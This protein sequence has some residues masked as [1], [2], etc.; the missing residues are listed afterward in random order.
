[1]KGLSITFVLAIL[2]L[3]SVSLALKA[4]Y[5]N[6]HVYQLQPKTAEQLELV[7]QLDGSRDSYIFLDA[8]HYVNSKIHV[9][10]AP[11]RVPDFVK[12]LENY[13]I[14]YELM[15]TN[16]QAHLEDDIVANPNRRS[17]DYSWTEYHEL[18]DT[19]NWL[20][21]LEQKY[22]GVVS[23]FKAG[24]TYEGRDILGVKITYG[25]GKK[26]I[27]LEGGMHAREW[28]GPATTT[29]ILNQL[30]SST[31]K[32]VRMIAESFDWYIVPHANPDG[33]VYTHT[34][35]RL[36]RKTRT[37]Y[38]NGCFGA[39]PNRNWDFHWNEIGASDNPCS[40]TYAGPSAFS[41]IETKTLAEYIATELKGKIFLFVSFHSYSQLLLFPYGHTNEL[42]PNYNDLKRVFDVA[43]DAAAERYGTKYTG[44]NIYDAIYPAAGASLDWAY[45]TQ[46]VKYAYCYE[47]RPSSLNF[48]TGF[49]L[50][51]SQIIPTG[52][53]TMDSLMA[54]IKEA[55]I[56]H[57]L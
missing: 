17:D 30:L 36:W 40:D 57:F 31:D 32:E 42:P 43:I 9:V 15:E 35:D 13:S 52:E 37:P 38:E 55:G 39:D 2:G 47:L 50:P 41:E 8:V 1:M 51:A 34:T 26:G 14:A 4:R 49:K 46:G 18:E 54:M 44:G 27:F 19:Y 10:V 56:T 48:W 25:P 22:P 5:D 28:I 24:R 6:Y 16:V 7:K 21:S 45:G 3:A 53:E 29:Y 23:I 12:A 33:F 11:H 20:H